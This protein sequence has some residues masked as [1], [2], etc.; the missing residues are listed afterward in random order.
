MD[1]KLKDVLTGSRLWAI[2][3]QSCLDGLLTLPDACVHT[4]V[5]SPPYWKLRD[6]ASVAQFGQES[7]HDCLAWAQSKPPCGQCYICSLRCVATEIRRV[8]REDGT[9]WLNIGD[10]RANAR[11]RSLKQKDLCML[12]ARV[13]LALQ[14]DGWYLRSVVHWCKLSPQPEPVND[15]PTDATED[16]ILFSRSKSY[17]YDKDAERVP[18]AASTLSRDEYTR[19]TSGKDGPYAVQHDHETPSHPDG[20]NLWNYWML[21]PNSFGWRMCEVCNRVYSSKQFHKLQRNS[22]RKRICSCGVS[23]WLSHFAA[24][25]T[26]LP[27][28]CI[29][30]TT[31]AAGVCATCSAPLHRHAHS[32]IRICG[33]PTTATVPAIVLDPFA[34]VG[35]TAL[36]ASLLGRR[37]IGF[38]TNDRYIT[39]AQ[40][41]IQ[42]VGGGLFF[43]A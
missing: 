2:A 15:R 35:T 39:L 13:A 31:P 22:S 43:V 33:C 17:F 21:K 37:S 9:F 32:W 28:R 11:G 42:D 34:G 25:P 41:R 3:H 7:M 29:K 14:A 16:I 20:R 38:D 6:Y 36:A 27:N 24:F 12:P 10:S 30:L 4:V 18:S 26:S 40:H 8:L 5:T 1:P 19:I 23:Q